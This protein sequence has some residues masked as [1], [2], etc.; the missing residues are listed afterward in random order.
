MSDMDKKLREKIKTRQEAYKNMELARKFSTEQLQ[1]KIEETDMKTFL[2][3]IS[4]DRLSQS[5]VLASSFFRNSVLGMLR[6]FATKEL[7]YNLLMH[8]HLLLFAKKSF[9]KGFLSLF[10]KMA[11]TREGKNIIFEKVP[12]I[13]LDRH[14]TSLC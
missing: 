10:Y 2:N 1:A 4:S 9:K 11:E 8:W 13:P 6:C 5:A 14:P 7:T 3:D 12:S